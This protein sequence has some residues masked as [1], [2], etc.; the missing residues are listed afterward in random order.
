[1][2]LDHVVPRSRGGTNRLKNLVLA[3]ATCNHRKGSLTVLE[4]L[5]TARF[6]HRWDSIRA[7]EARCG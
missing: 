4:Y 6:Q 5:G 2:T 7:E 3:C 1:M